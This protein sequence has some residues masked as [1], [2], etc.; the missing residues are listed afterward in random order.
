M[1][2]VGS[3]ARGCVSSTLVIVVWKRCYA[4]VPLESG[5]G[6]RGDRWRFS[7]LFFV[8][9]VWWVRLFSFGGQDESF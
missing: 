4:E 2:L 5:L 1:D 7:F 9:F 3:V 8:F 6:R